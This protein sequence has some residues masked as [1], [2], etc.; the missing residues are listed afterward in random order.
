M[1]PFAFQNLV[2]DKVKHL[3]PYLPGRSIS[4]IQKQYHVQDVIK[5][6][7]NENPLGCS[8]DVLKK[9][10]NISSLDLS[11]YPATSQHPLLQDL[12]EFLN[13]HENQ[14]LITNGSDAG[15]SLLIQAFACPFQKKI[16]THEYAFMGYE[17]QASSFGIDTLKA[18]VHPKSWTVDIAHL[19]KL[20]L[21]KP[22]I[23]FIAN[24]NNPTG[25]KLSWEEI[26]SLLQTL[27]PETLLVLDEAYHEYDLTP[28]PPLHTLLN[29][30]SN[31]IITRTFSKA[32]GLAGLRIGY[33]MAHPQVIQT[34]KRIQLPFTINQ[35]ALNAAHIPL[36]D[37]N[38]IRQTQSNN[39]QGMEFLIQ[40][41]KSTPLITRPSW[42]N[43]ITIEDENP[44]QPLVQYLESQGIIIRG[45]QAF[46]LQNVARITVGTPLQNE[47]LSL[48]LHNYFQ[49]KG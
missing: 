38:F 41:L 20:T 14:I 26:E 35:Q 6:A 40:A 5:L 24:P 18:S 33:L 1:E 44:I 48:A 8:P 17:I 47:R 11:I 42:G 15:F 25:L 16:L 49:S 21:E 32:Y 27:S 30:Y 43:F 45:L 3:T 37:Q 39:Q 28:H 12:C 31:L 13:I 9:L 19:K 22:A 10:Q 4:E 7:S 23:V 46:G 2:S 29:T 34:L 36:K